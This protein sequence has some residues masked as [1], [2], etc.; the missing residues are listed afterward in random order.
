VPVV[1]RGAEGV[2]ERIAGKAPIEDDECVLGQ[3][4]P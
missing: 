4:G 3:G 2:K 1:L